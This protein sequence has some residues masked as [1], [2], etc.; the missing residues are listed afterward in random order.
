MPV[1]LPGKSHRQR[2]LVGYS[3]WG[4]KMVGHDL[5]TKLQ[6]EEQVKSRNVREGRE[7]AVGKEKRNSLCAHRSRNKA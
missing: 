4:C 3:P 1:S 2:N 5:A 7:Q 6:Q